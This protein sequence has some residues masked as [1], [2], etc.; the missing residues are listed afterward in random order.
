MYG[1]WYDSVYE[2]S[3]AGKGAVVIALWGYCCCKADP[4]DH[5]VL[6]NPSLLAAKIGEPV[7]AIDRA[8]AFLCSPDPQSQ[9]TD[10]DGRRL[11]HMGGLR[12]FVVT[13]E[14]YRNMRNED[15]RREY[16]RQYM[17]DYRNPVNKKANKSLPKL[18][19]AS[20]SVSAS[21]SASDSE[22][23]TGGDAPAPKPTDF[24]AFW[25][26]YP[27]KVGKKAA[28]KAWQ[29]AKD[30]PPLA[31]LLASIEANKAGDAWTRDGGQF[32]PHPATWINQGRWEDE[33]LAP[34]PAGGNQR[35]WVDFGTGGL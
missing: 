23:G 3:M 32:I 11:L 33:V 24:D 1:K 30:R 18:T 4:E 8:V 7:D 34:R 5:S 6:L 20:A 29:H 13:H 12:Y 15:D 10:H 25:S 19:P 14:H 35:S 2:G 22:G 21:A 16:M 28:L 26:A 17:R 9:N 31:D 27:R